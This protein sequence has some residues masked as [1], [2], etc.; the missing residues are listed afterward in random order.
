MQ[1]LGHN[2]IEAIPTASVT[3]ETDLSNSVSTLSNNFSNIHKTVERLVEIQEKHIEIEK[4]YF[5]FMRKIFDKLIECISH[6]F[7]VQ[8]ARTNLFLDDDFDIR[9]EQHD[10]SLAILLKR[11]DGTNRGVNLPPSSDIFKDIGGATRKTEEKNPPLHWK[12]L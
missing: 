4:V 12:F 8:S 6:G 10:A 9:E 11:P 3:M 1:G 7:T 5:D 2:N